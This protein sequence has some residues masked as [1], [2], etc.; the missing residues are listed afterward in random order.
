MVAANPTK[1]T[2][3]NAAAETCLSDAPAETVLEADGELEVEPE[4]LE[5]LEVESEL[6]VAVVKPVLADW[7]PVVVA[8]AV[9]PEI[10]VEELI[11]EA[12]L[13][14]SAL[15]TVYLCVQLHTDFVSV[16][17]ACTGKVR[18]SILLV[19]IVALFRNQILHLIPILDA[20]S[21]QVRRIRLGT[22]YRS[23]CQSKIIPNPPLSDGMSRPHI[24]HGGKQTS[25]R[26]SSNHHVAERKNGEENGGLGEKHGVVCAGVTSVVR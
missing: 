23:E 6:A 11:S 1:T 24:P 9:E 19:I 5:E 14:S 18:Q 22:L 8:V 3:A 10:V 4:E 21:L 7:E 2:A 16:G 12:L 17:R 26:L 20:N 25:R 13:A 15:Y